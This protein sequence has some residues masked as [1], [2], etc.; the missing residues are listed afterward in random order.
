MKVDAFI[1]LFTFVF[2]Q[3]I[4]YILLFVATSDVGLVPPSGIARG[5]VFVCRL[6]CS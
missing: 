6:L 1:F 2:I 5:F 3:L 4:D